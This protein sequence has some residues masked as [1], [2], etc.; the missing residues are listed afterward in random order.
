MK[1]T[2]NILMFFLSA[3]IAALLV[4]IS[5]DSR[6]HPQNKFHAYVA[7]T[8]QPCCVVGA[9]SMYAKETLDAELTPAFIE[10][11]V[12]LLNRPT[13]EVAAIVPTWDYLFPSNQLVSIDFS[14]DPVQY[15]TPYIW[16]GK[17]TDD[18]NTY[19]T[20]LVY[21]HTNGVTY[22]HFVYDPHTHTNYMVTTNYDHF[23]TRTIGLYTL[24]K[25]LDKN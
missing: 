21:L 22:K 13:V 18:T 15:E 3:L 9:F 16:T 24:K 25:E 5:L 2:F 19:H 14:N 6:I 23:F 7:E 1:T 4:F 10:T 20:C 12:L 8:N 17:W 11:N